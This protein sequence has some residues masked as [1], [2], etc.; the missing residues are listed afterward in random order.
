[1]FFLQCLCDIL[2]DNS[3]IQKLQLSSSSFG[4]EVSLLLAFQL[5]ATRRAIT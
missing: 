2:A 3:G 5:V 4:D 1:M